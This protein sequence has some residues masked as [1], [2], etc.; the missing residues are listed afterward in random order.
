MR[1][2]IKLAALA[3]LVLTP[4]AGRADADW[5]QAPPGKWCPAQIV[6]HL[7]LVI[8]GSAGVFESRRQHGPMRRRPRSPK[9][10]AGYWLLSRVGWIPGRRRAPAL[11]RPGE[12][13]ERA[14]VERQFREAV[15]RFLVVEREL[16]PARGSDLF[17]KHSALGDL[18]LSEWGQFHIW[19]CRHHAAQIRDRLAG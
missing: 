14:V 1:R 19:H 16:L 10:V 15:E 8:D 12:R 7:A 11:M 9:E 6:Q 18:T 2:V 17:V 4:L 3:D 13:P 5:Y